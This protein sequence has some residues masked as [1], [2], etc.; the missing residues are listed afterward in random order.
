MSFAT[1]VYHENQRRLGIGAER[2]EAPRASL[3]ARFETSV[4]TSG[5]RQRILG[6]EHAIEA[7]DR[8]LRIVQSRLQDPERPL[9]S[10]LLVGPT[11]VGKTE[12]VRRLAAEI[13]SGPDDF[14][15]V[16][17]GALAQEHYSASF[18]GAPPGY[19]GSK[20][21]YSVFDRGSIE[22]DP[23]TPGIVLFD[24]VEKAHPVVLRALL[25]ILD[26]GILRLS[27]GQQTIN[28]RNSL[29]FLT[30]NLG[31]REIAERHVREPNM[32]LPLR[33]KARLRPHRPA[34]HHDGPKSQEQLVTGAV[35]KF[36]D[37]EFLNRI[38]EVVL[39][40]EIDIGAA[41][42]IADLELRLLAARLA[43]E[44]VDINVAPS[45]PQL[46]CDLG[47]NS[48]YGAR[49][50]RRTL[51]RHVLP[52]LAD[53]LVLAKNNGARSVNIALDVRDQQVVAEVLQ[54]APSAEAVT[55]RRPST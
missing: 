35:Q 14:C 4:V 51:Q 29:I 18:A 10:F 28:F 52:P 39:F 50:L 36:F 9:V 54:P 45:V 3:A 44:E 12:L 41:R 25:Q 43:R 33:T 49:S 30:S 20:E 2:E 22:G 21:G 53:A 17:M 32:R 16:D 1:D 55:F 37:P 46:I 6:Q 26:R 13:R 24:E 34:R 42:A 27:N 5:L 31:S 23:Y 19:A 11:G 48:L 7:V 40:R 38:D 15:R 47:F 8:C